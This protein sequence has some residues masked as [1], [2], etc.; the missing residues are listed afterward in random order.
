MSKEKSIALLSA[1]KL[2]IGY[3]R[4]SIDPLVILEDLSLN[5]FPGELITFIG[6]NG[7]GKS[8]L[9]KSLVGLIPKLGGKIFYKNQSADTI[10]QS[11]KAEHMGVVLTEPVYERNMSIFDLVSIGRYPHT[12][13]L[14]KLQGVDLLKVNQ[15]IEQVG[16]KHKA[17][18]LLC[19]LSDGEKQ[20]AM[21]A[22]VLAQ[23][24]DLIIL[25]EPT[26]HLD[27]SNR[28]D[29]LILLKKLAHEFGKGILLST[30]ELG[31]ALQVSD[32]IWMIGKDKTLI[33]DIPEQIIQSGQLDRVFGNS[34]ISFQ[35]WSASFEILPS[36][37]QV[38]KVVGSGL[39]LAC[40]VRLLR[41]H[42]FVIKFE[43]E[44][45]DLLLEVNENTIHIKNNVNE[46]RKVKSLLDLQTFLQAFKK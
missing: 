15:A 2:T 35:P 25:D 21:I 42:G 9:I 46:V 18:A 10:T 11:Q 29:V 43:D 14:G 20:R 13:W 19:E 37:D 4:A 30:H 36:T 26:A 34:V 24:V 44:G 33:S 39:L 41:R 31:M 45:Y 27:L 16:L 22:R 12:N 17:S 23:D 7:S 38:V 3:Q 32:R 8:T 6:P 40:V 5:I 1:D 28:M